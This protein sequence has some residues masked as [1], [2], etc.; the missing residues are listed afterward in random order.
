M[1]SNNRFIISTWMTYISSY[2]ASTRREN[3]WIWSW[4]TG[5]TP[6]E[7]YD[8]DRSSKILI[9]WACPLPIA[10]GRAIRLYSQVYHR[11][12]LLF[13]VASV[14][15]PLPPALHYLCHTCSYHFYPSRRRELQV[16]SFK[17]LVRCILFT[18]EFSIRLTPAVYAN[19]RL[20]PPFAVYAASTPCSPLLM[21]KVGCRPS[22]LIYVSGYI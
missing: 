20:S 2:C 7:K 13:W 1:M 12:S 10:R 4:Y 9:F 5:I 21:L 15:S 22:S 18:P 3:I 11:V 6:I 19:G 8:I 17:L 14:R 16:S